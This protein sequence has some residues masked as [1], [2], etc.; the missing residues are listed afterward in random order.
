M[1]IFN[2]LIN[3]LLSQYLVLSE[4]RHRGFGVGYSGI[5]NLGTQL[6]PVGK[7]LLHHDEGWPN[8]TGRFG[9]RIIGDRMAGEAI[10]LRISKY[11]RPSRGFLGNLGRHGQVR[12]TQAG[13]ERK[14][15]GRLFSASLL[16]LHFFEHSPKASVSLGKICCLCKASILNLSWAKQAFFKIFCFISDS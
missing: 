5:P 14:Q 4:R 6:V 13:D 16:L 7:A 2:N 15:K 1:Y 9:L 12:D 10:A 8:V 3:F 11:D